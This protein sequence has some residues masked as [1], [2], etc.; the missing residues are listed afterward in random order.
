[1][2][3]NILIYIVI[4]LL[5]LLINIEYLETQQ[6]KWGHLILSYMKIIVQGIILVDMVTTHI[7]WVLLIPGFIEVVKTNIV[8]LRVL[9]ISIITQEKIMMESVSV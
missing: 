1:M 3:A 6:E 4:P 7:S 8:C 2:K 9:F 5:I